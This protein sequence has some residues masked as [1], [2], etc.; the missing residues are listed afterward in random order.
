MIETNMIVKY[1]FEI[2][3]K[4]FAVIFLIELVLK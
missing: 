1:F 2:S 4:I 3:D